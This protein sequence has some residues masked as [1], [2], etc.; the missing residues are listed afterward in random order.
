MNDTGS[1]AGNGGAE[2]KEFSD[3]CGTDDG[4]LLNKS[5]ED[6]RG[7]NTGVGLLNGIEIT[8][9]NDGGTSGGSEGGL[10]LNISVEHFT[11][12][13]NDDG[14]GGKYSGSLSSTASTPNSN[15]KRSARLSGLSSKLS[16]AVAAEFHCAV[17]TSPAGGANLLYW[18]ST[19][20]FDGGK[21]Y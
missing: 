19:L 2:V 13:G 7:G 10:L 11:V 20:E 4:G 15:R 18:L 1:G 17:Q 9:G 8:G 6:G 14:E 12:G 21:R 16:A 5:N 3:I